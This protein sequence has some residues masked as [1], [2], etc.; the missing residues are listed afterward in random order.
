MKNW[1]LF[2]SGPALAI[3]T[4]PRP[5]NCFFSFGFQMD[6]EF[7]AYFERLTDLIVEWTTPY[8]LSTFARPRRIA[9]LYHEILDITVKQCAVVCP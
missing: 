7:V 9:A 1:A 3:A 2:V 6:L 4:I 5:L 8:T